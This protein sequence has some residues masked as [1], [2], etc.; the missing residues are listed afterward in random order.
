M[1]HLIQSINGLRSKIMR[2]IVLTSN[3]VENFANTNKHVDELLF[4]KCNIQ[5]K[6]MQI[7]LRI[8]QL[9]ISL[10]V[11]FLMYLKILILIKFDI[12]KFKKVC[13]G[14]WDIDHWYI[15]T[16]EIG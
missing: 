14:H 10:L 15:G 4:C 16:L 2:I 13:F 11:S 1:V 3:V 8:I 7:M 6:N 9:Y 5:L 12:T